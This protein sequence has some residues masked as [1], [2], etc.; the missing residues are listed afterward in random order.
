MGNGDVLQLTVKRKYALE[1]NQSRG[2]RS[3]LIL[4]GQIVLL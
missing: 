4:L 3:V 1:V 2:L